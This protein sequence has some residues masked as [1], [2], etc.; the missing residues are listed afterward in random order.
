[1]PKSR[2]F[3][4][5]ELLVVISIIAILSVVGFVSF[6]NVQKN[7][8]D[9]KIKADL[10]AIKKA[11]EVN[12]IVDSTHPQGAYQ[13]LKN[14]MFASGKIPTQ[15]NGSPYPCSVGPDTTCSTNKTSYPEADQGYKVSATLSDGKD[16]T[17]TSTAGTLVQSGMLSCD[18]TGTLKNG[19]AGWWKMDENSW[20]GT[21]G[22]VKDSS[23]NNQNG[24]SNCAGGS[25]CVKPNTVAGK[26]GKAGEF[27]GVDDLVQIP[28]Q[29]TKFA[30]NSGT[31]ALWINHAASQSGGKGWVSFSD[32]RPRFYSSS[33]SVQIY[34]S[35]ATGF[36]AGPEYSSAFGYSNNA[37]HHV[38]FLWNAAAS[39]Y[40]IYLDGI[41]KESKT[42]ITFSA[43][44]TGAEEFGRYGSSNY[45]NG[46]MDDV[47][48][49]NRA[50]STA[51][52]T[53]L[54]NNGSGCF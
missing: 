14:E 13:P 54:Y 52:V 3:T 53:Q 29:S 38:V 30:V 34:W 28:D 17:V 45:F 35:G 39:T 42:N 12:Y 15:P 9:A 33:D 36:P 50:L 20:N 49:Y 46:Q 7:A 19:L 16:Y 44:T 4:L 43:L 2:G 40:S 31:I 26:I 5:I 6:Q 51:E 11:Y 37:W 25:G 23:G 32:G 41:L 22:E 8:K 10:D 18:P 48:I 47:R 21:A 27:D 24:I 1:M